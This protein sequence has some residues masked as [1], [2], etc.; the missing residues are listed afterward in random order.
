[1]GEPQYGI[2]GDQGTPQWTTTNVMDGSADLGN[3]R[4]MTPSVNDGTV[5]LIDAVLSRGRC[6]QACP[7]RVTGRFCRWPGTGTN[8]SVD[9]RCENYRSTE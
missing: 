2:S 6:T 8:T 1:M 9:T 7:D 5:M 4:M 3:E